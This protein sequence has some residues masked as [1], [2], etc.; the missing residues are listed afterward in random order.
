MSGGGTSAS[1]YGP[2]APQGGQGTGISGPQ[3]GMQ[4]SP[5]QGNV[6][7]GG[8]AMPP[9]LHQQLNQMMQNGNFGTPQGGWQGQFGPPMQQQQ[10]PPPMSNP[11]QGGG[12][13]MSPQMQQMAMQHGGQMQG[14]QA[15][16][17]AHYAY[18]SYGQ[19]AQHANPMQQ[20]MQYASAPIGGPSAGQ[21]YSPAVQ[22]QLAA[23]FNSRPQLSDS[24][25][26]PAAAGSTTPGSSGVTGGRQST[27]YMYT[28]PAASGG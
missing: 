20:Y 18:Q 16:N 6:G 3:Q 17:P 15:V 9:A 4:A 8:A 21:Q 27:P 28:K 1:P 12:V 13:G 19:Q 25:T 10:V 23:Q 22:A 5:Q 24:V 2:N 7:F 14:P 11:M 26:P